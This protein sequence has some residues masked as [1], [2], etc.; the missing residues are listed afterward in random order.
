RWDRTER[1]W[2]AIVQGEGKAADNTRAAVETAYAQGQDDEFVIPCVIGDPHPMRDGDQVICFNFRA[3]RAR[4]LTAA[5]ALE[6][7]TGF[8]RPRFPK[9]GYVCMT[10][11][12]R[13]FDLPL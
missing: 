7:F 11:Y 5:L 12:D 2:R 1:A 6:S 4:Q 13:S 10:E 8:A 3:D 9:V